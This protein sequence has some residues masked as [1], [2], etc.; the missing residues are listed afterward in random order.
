MIYLDIAA[1]IIAFVVLGVIV[2]AVMLMNYI[3]RD[4]REL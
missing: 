4:E 2:G 1:A 3:G